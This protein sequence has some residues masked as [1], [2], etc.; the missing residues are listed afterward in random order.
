MAGPAPVAQQVHMELEL[1]SGRRE[2]EHL[3]VQL[4]EGRTGAQQAQTRSHT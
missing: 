1:L 3:I 4:L 2:G